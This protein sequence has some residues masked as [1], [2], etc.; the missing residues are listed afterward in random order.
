MFPIFLCELRFF[1]IF[2]KSPKPVY[3]LYY[4]FGTFSKYH[5]NNE[6]LTNCI[7]FSHMGF[8]RALPFGSAPCIDIFA[9]TIFPVCIIL[10]S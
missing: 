2:Q 1:A 10:I 3:Y 4:W 7:F 8:Q 6:V 5:Q 9:V